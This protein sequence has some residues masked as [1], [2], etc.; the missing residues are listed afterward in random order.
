MKRAFSIAALVIGGAC[1]SDKTPTTDSVNVDSLVQSIKA[2]GAVLEEATNWKVTPTG[3]G[4]VSAGMALSEANSIL[5]ETLKPGSR[6]CEM[7]RPT[8]APGGVWLM[9]QNDTV[10]RVDIDSAYVT[11]AENVG[12]GDTEQVVK[13][14]YAGRITTQPHKYQPGN[15]LMVSATGDPR[16]KLIFE[17]DGKVVIRF[18]AGRVPEV[19]WVERCG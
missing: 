14:T 6:S 8:K 15:Y 1:G 4:T 5:G 11:T 13:S 18:R 7:I 10:M 9:V 16:H 3:I 17:T 2:P 19:E 12:I